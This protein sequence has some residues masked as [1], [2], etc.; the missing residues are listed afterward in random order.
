MRHYTSA[1][2]KRGE[3]GRGRPSSS[4]IAVVADAADVIGP[5]QPVWVTYE[6]A[7]RVPKKTGV[8]GQRARRV[9]YV[10]TVWRYKCR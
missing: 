8:R 5:D 2:A 7:G 10:R 4:V 6:H 3:P 9:E 1:W